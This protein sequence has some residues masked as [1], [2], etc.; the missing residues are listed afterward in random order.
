MIYVKD[1]EDLV[2]KNEENLL[3]KIDKEKKSA[4]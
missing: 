3:V 2:V 4:K 1:I